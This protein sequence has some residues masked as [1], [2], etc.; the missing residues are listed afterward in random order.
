MIAISLGSI[1]SLYTIFFIPSIL[2]GSRSFI[3][4]QDDFL[5]L[6]AFIRYILA[7]A[8]G[9]VTNHKTLQ[10]VAIFKCALL[11]LR[12]ALGED[13][14]FQLIKFPEHIG[15]NAIV[16]G[17]KV[18][19]TILVVFLATRLDVGIIEVKVLQVTSHK[20]FAIFHIAT[21]QE[22]DYADV[23]TI[24]GTRNLQAII[25][26]EVTIDNERIVA[27]DFKT[28]FICQSSCFSKRY[29]EDTCLLV[30]YRLNVVGILLGPC[31]LIR[32]NCRFGHV[33]NV[34]VRNLEEYIIS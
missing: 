16:L 34:V 25:L 32:F 21:T 4:K 1:E 5:E 30:A 19:R 20:F 15:I 9:V 33:D 13:K 31:G 24:D 28:K 14:G 22:A 8:I 10:I 27:N 3:T 2:V 17:D 11:N 18:V 23:R 6:S 26:A 7:N 12:C 29:F